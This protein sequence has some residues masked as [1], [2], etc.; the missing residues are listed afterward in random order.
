MTLASTI[1]RQPIAP[2]VFGIKL[3]VTIAFVYHRRAGTVIWSMIVVIL[4]TRSRNDARRIHLNVTLKVAFVNG[5]RMI[6]ICL[7]GSE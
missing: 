5:R 7:I 2:L 1:V 6:A 4:V 3:D